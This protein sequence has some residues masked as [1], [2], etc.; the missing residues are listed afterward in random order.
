MLPVKAHSLQ[1]ELTSPHAWT[2]MSTVN[3]LKQN[4]K[5]VG[6]TYSRQF[7]LESDL[8]VQRNLMH[9]FFNA[10]T[11][12]Y[13]TS[14]YDH[15]YTSKEVWVYMCGI[16]NLTD[17]S[18]GLVLWITYISYVNAS[19]MHLDSS[20]RQDELFLKAPFVLWK[21]DWSGVQYQSYKT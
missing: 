10:K 2:P 13:K 12:I 19:L 4:T 15:S 3:Y 11:A 17:W 14:V 8:N 7:A 1:P 6:S 18:S 20:A 5:A 9:L 21:Q 16:R